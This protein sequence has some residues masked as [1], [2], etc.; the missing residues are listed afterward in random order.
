MRVFHVDD[1]LV[2]DAE[3]RIFL[4]GPTPRPWVEPI[5]SAWR[6]EAIRLFE[7]FG[8]DGNIFIPESRD[9]ETFNWEYQVDWEDEQ[10]NAADCILF[11]IPRVLETMP[12]FTT[13]VEWGRW[14]NSGK[15]VLGSPPEAKKMGYIRHYAKKHGVPIAD[16]LKG[17][18]NLAIQMANSI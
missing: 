15:V 11:W 18:V 2:D 10:M 17:T 4:A 8:F 13:N 7:Q 12:G 3:K 1:P 14:E 6:P 16:T 9:L 5:V